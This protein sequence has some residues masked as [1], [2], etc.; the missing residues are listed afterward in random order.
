MASSTAALRL[1]AAVALRSLSD[2]RIRVIRRPS[3]M[4]CSVFSSLAL[5]MFF[6]SVRGSSG[7]SSRVVL[8]N[9]I[10][11][12]LIKMTFDT[13]AMCKMC[14]VTMV[15]EL[16]KLR[17]WYATERRLDNR[18][19]KRTK[20]GT[21]RYGEKD[22]PDFGGTIFQDGRGWRAGSRVVE[23]FARS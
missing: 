9:R 3:S 20:L 19:K 22:N 23:G 11:D 18:F 6:R 15:W 4:M 14:F 21:L 5:S 2:I 7:G 17:N 8:F 16:L 12:S 10:V 13:L 1:R